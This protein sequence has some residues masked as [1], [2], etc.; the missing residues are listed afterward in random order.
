MSVP[1]MNS[2]APNS[3]KIIST[4]NLILNVIDYVRTHR[5]ETYFF[6]LFFFSYTYTHIQLAMLAS[7]FAEILFFFAERSRSETKEKGRFPQNSVSGACKYRQLDVPSC[8]R[9]REG[10][11]IAKQFI[12]CLQF[13]PKSV[14]CLLYFYDYLLSVCAMCHI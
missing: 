1:L 3:N 13:I 9:K 6:F 2:T 5:T 11:K 7:N 12:N 8:R 4:I 10:K 14:D